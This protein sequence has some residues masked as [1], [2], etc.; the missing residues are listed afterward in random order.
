MKE[1]A[2]YGKGGIGKSTISANVSAAFG[3]QK[4][5]VLQVGCDPKHDST[6]LLLHGEVPQTVLDYL[7]ET[8]PDK[9]RLQDIVFEG[10]RGIHCVEAGGPEPG[11]GCAGRGILTTFELLDRLGVRKSAYD[12]V[13]Y[14]VLG[15][16]VCG[17]FA[18]PMR[19]EYADEVYIVT[20][21]EYMS[22]YAANNILRGLKNYDAEKHRAGGIIFNARN[23]E[24]EAGR[25]KRFAEAVGLPILASIPRSD[26]FA[27]SER[28]GCCLLEA[29]PDSEIAEMFKDLAA[30][31][32]AAPALYPAAPLSDLELER[33]VLGRDKKAPAKVSVP[34]ALD[35]AQA[36]EE[37][38]FFSK[39]L[40]AREPLHGCAF[41][42]A[43]GIAVM[44]K[45]SLCLA[46]GPK[47]CAHI[48]YQSITSIGRK[49][50][51]ERGI[52]LPMQVA[53]PIV[54]S[55]MNESVMVFG[56]IEELR[57]KV[58]AL[59]EK[60]PEVI[61]VL[62]TCPSG[63]IGDDVETIT[64]LA[65]AD[66]KIVLI[67]T[68]GNIT[69]DYLQGIIEAYVTIGRSLIDK[70]VNPRPDTVNLIAEKMVAYV[71]PENYKNIKA[72]LDAL[73]LH[74][75]C[76]FLYEA[77]PEEIKNLMRG[78]LNLLAYSDYMGRTVRSFLEKEYGAVFLDAPFPVG[79]EETKDWLRQVAHFFGKD[80]LTDG[81]I[82]DYETAYDREIAALKPY[83]KGKKLMVVTYNHNIEWILKTAV[84]LEMDIQLVGVL[85]YSQDNAFA[86]AYRDQIGELVLNYN[87]ERRRQD[88]DRLKPDLLLANYIS[89]DL[90]GAVSTDT[91]P[92]CPEAGFMS[93]VRLAR[94]WCDVFK[95]NL[96]EGWKQDEALYRKYFA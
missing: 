16:V 24:D 83:L 46:H 25:V 1:I 94:R 56:G 20:S 69:G 92:L 66:T 61:F 7:R 44:V 75:N 2:I 26:L 21:G 43:M 50:L 23:L 47:S 79:M 65:T 27:A 60:K 51:L 84:D 73:G 32:D 17:G 9:C 86:T 14:D 18:V 76:R 63:I 55:E 39:N 38:Q 34:I 87:Q 80:H 5:R 35:A 45:N 67:K 13:L 40:V 48:T 95:L 54:S 89:Q 36:P 28:S 71:T 42:G 31:I 41:S 74:I 72:L 96:K 33:V 57:L 30:R 78:S 64:Q 93:G 12:L 62:T 4:K 11:V 88:I 3:N 49:T 77:E 91:I 29:Y 19:R 6:R 58:K 37:N 59:L 52:V 81:I 90:D 53:P 82:A 15:D 85:N 8:A 10:W 70:T 22:I 68:D